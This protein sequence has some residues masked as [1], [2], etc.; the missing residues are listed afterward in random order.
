MSLKFTW[1]S[2]GIKLPY[3]VLILFAFLCPIS[4]PWMRYKSNLHWFPVLGKCWSWQWSW[5]SSGIYKF[6]CW[7]RWSG[8]G[9]HRL[10]ATYLCQSRRFVEFVFNYFTCWNLNGENPRWVFF[11]GL[12]DMQKWLEFNLGRAAFCIQDTRW[13]WKYNIIH[14]LK[15]YSGV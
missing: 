13:I 1:C 11:W 15:I 4:G 14:K 3:F 8:I 10:F 7:A 9:S 12:H 6:L 5:Y 2:F